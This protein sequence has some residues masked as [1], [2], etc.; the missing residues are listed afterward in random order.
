MSERQDI[1]EK[2][3]E[4]MAL[5]YETEWVEFKEAK[6]NYDFDDLGKYLSALSNEANLNKQQAGWLVFGVTNH[7][8]RHAVGTNYRHQ[9]PGLERLKQEIAQHTNHQLTFHA[10]HEVIDVGKRVVLFK[11]PAASRGIPTT[12][13]GIAYGRIH[14][15]LKPLT[16][17]KIERIRR[18]ATYED[19][20]AQICPEATLSDLDPEA[21]AFGRRQYK[22]KNP[23]LVHEVDKWD[24]LTFLN[25]TRA[26]A[27]GQ[28][29]RAAI[30]L[31]G[32]SE[33][34]RFLSPATA[35]ITWVIRDEKGQERDY[36]HFYPP[37]ILT[38][39]QVF[40]KIRNNTYRYLPNA[41]LFPVEITQYDPWVIREVL[42]NA[43]AH[44]DYS[45]GGHINVVEEPDLLL[46]TNLGG[47]LPG[48]VEEVIR[49]DS[50]PE[51]YRNRLLA[52]AMVSFNMIDT[53]GSG[54]K[55]MFT[56]QR[57]RF[58]PLPD[59]DLSEA[60]RVKVRIFGKILD[61]QYTR[62]LIEKT[63][64]DLWA[65]IALDKVQKRKPL[66][67][68]EFGLLKRKGLVEGR[69]PNLY[70]SAKVAAATETKA[71]YI[72]KRAFDKQHYVKMVQE[73]LAKFRTATRPDF[74]KLLLDKISDALSPE[75]KRNFVTNLLQEM[76]RKGMI[77][78]VREGKRGKGT[79]WELYKPRAE[80]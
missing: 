47:F 68:E 78:P 55:R 69:R 26:C 74:D 4:L 33:A 60:E 58:F 80:G 77:R 43:I 72:R 32:R 52:E 14:D 38:V 65:V 7:P 75:Q 17:D 12:W 2:L 27:S 20:S 22:E 57:E 3:R 10:I 44:Q 19:W 50:P 63:D 1:R 18:Q 25:K 15:S 54:I 39:D 42:H 71:D 5:P 28:V 67:D 76:R 46:F 21:I 40:A 49:R 13:K 53:I 31:M 23:K 41:T 79:Q 6:N 34:T 37:F 61:E 48:S 30:V 51:L 59:Y 29:T 16:L 62:V 64:L 9:P 73:Y 45:E 56:K 24:E 36:M 70:V 8:P 35:R 66:T 11:I